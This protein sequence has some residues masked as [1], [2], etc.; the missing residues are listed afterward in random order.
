MMYCSRFD[1]VADFAG[2]PVGLKLLVPSI[3]CVKSM[4]K[5]VV[6]SRLTDPAGVF[7]LLGV[8]DGE[9]DDEG[10]FRDVR[11]VAAFL[12]LGVA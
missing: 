1:S 10:R 11:G 5:L 3:C 8:G 4:R 7:C 12:P 9:R 2:E 6:S